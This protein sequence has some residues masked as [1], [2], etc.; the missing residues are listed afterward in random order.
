MMDSR[1][2]IWILVAA[3]SALALMAWLLVQ[4]TCQSGMSDF[5]G[6]LM[7]SEVVALPDGGSM[8]LALQSADGRAVTLTRTG[9]LAIEA[10]K[11]NMHVVFWVA[12]IPVRCDAPKGSWLESEARRALRAWLEDKLTPQQEASLAKGDVETL[13]TVP[14]DVIGAYNFVSWIES[15]V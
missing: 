11:Q 7:V 6:Q 14:F 10:T 4:R 12:L 15:R 1:R 5:N 8:T 3:G 2:R 13:R 9:S